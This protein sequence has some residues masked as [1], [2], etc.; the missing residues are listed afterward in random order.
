L[1]FSMIYSSVIAIVCTLNHTATP[2]IYNL[3]LHDALPIS[4]ALPP[5]GMSR[6]GRW[7]A[8]APDRRPCG[9]PSLCRTPAGG[10]RLHPDSLV[11]EDRKSTR[12]NSSHVKISYAVFCLKKKTI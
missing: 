3:S 9:L 8:R 10:P 7:R 11:G 6:R 4:C 1:R 12:L 2:E 5:S